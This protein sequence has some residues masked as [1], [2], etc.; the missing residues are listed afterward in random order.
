MPLYFTRWHFSSFL[1]SAISCQILEHGREKKFLI[2][3]RSICENITVL[4]AI[5]RY[6][7]NSWFMVTTCDQYF[8]LLRC[9]IVTAQRN[10]P[11]K[12]WKVTRHPHY[13]L[14][15]VT[16]QLWSQRTLAP[17]QNNH[18]PVQREPQP[19]CTTKRFWLARSL[20]IHQP[21]P[22]Q[23]HPHWPLGVREHLNAFHVHVNFDRPKRKKLCPQQSELTDRK[24]AATSRNQKK[25]KTK[26]CSCATVTSIIKMFSNSQPIK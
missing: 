4:P 20:L 13:L 23:D 24:F 11:E 18:C 1:H 12:L 7:C 3:K 9:L 22:V 15:F 14:Y 2:S 16:A 26:N 21:L 6:Q 5:T 19:S 10:Y 25:K 17:H 8:Q